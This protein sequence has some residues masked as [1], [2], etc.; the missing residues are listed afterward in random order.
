M[1][2]KNR[3]KYTPS[4]FK[5]AVQNKRDD[6]AVFFNSFSRQDDELCISKN[7]FTHINSKCRYVRDAVSKCQRPETFI[8]SPRCVMYYYYSNKLKCNA[9]YDVENVLIM[10]SKCH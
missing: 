6:R 3:K 8:L 2:L 4:K 7:I 10:T 1:Y 9:V 5:K